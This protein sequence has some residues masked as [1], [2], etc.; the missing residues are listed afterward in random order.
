MCMNI[1]VVCENH[2]II[3][4]ISVVNFTREYEPSGVSRI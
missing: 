2:I 4:F 1:S 3:K